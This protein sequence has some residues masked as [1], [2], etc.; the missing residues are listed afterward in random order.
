MHHI[1]GFAISVLVAM[2]SLAFTAWTPAWWICVIIAATI[3]VVTGIHIIWPQKLH[4]GAVIQIYHDAL[5]Y[6]TRK[7]QGNFPDGINVH[8]ISFYIPDLDSKGI[9]HIYI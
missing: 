8:R 3:A 7:S 4:L 6:I 2:L 1:F 5:R 9:L